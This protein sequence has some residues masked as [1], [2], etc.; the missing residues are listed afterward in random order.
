MLKKIVLG[1]SLIVL[2]GG[3]S[4]DK[5]CNFNECGVVA[6]ASEITAVSNYLNSQSITNAV[7]HCSGVFYVIENAGSGKRPDACSP[8]NVTYA[9]HLTNG[10]LFDQGTVDIGLYQV[11]RGWR[12]A[13]PQIREGGRIRIFIPPSL[14]YGQ[15]PFG[16]IPGNSILVFTVDL[17]QVL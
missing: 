6:P 12:T 10:T 13:I 11:I 8:V 7:Q 14:G 15:A 5:D 2:L 17:H 16:P 3:C 9:G 1:I 4:K